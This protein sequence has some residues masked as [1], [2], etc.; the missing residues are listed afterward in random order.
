MMEKYNTDAQ[1]L[2]TLSLGKIAASRVQRGGVNLHKSLLVSAILHKARN[3]Y[4][5]ENLQVLMESRKASSEK[6]STDNTSS[7]VC[8]ENGACETNVAP[9]AGKPSTCDKERVITSTENKENDPTPA[10][11]NT[12]PVSDENAQSRLT[13]A[14]TENNTS[15]TNSGKNSD[16][17][18]C[19]TKRRLTVSTEENIDHSAA[20]KGK[21]DTPVH[22]LSESKQ[23]NVVETMQTENIQINNLVNSFSSG[24]GGLVDS[25]CNTTNQLSSGQGHSVDKPYYCS[26]QTKN[27][28]KDRYDTIALPIMALA[29]A[30]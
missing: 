28:I 7:L 30:V 11:D 23:N 19:T 13:D 2:I 22:E 24:F 20:K 27:H 25:R 15:S 5:I 9:T 12:T 6:Q 29:V 10:Q 18:R 16:C 17:A 3:A 14:N 8:T 1:R 26:T 4:M 21:S